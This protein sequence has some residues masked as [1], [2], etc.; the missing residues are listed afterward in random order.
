[1]AV[2]AAARSD[3][4]VDSR[5]ERR[6]AIGRMMQEQR[7]LDQFEFHDVQP[8]RRI[9]DHVDAGIDR[10]R[11]RGRQRL[12]RKDPRG[13]RTEEHTSELQSLMR[14]SYAVFCLKKQKRQN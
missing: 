10:P 8:A 13:I 1:M 2:A 9:A 4:A 7:R 3:G 5:S 14:L 11:W 6:A 12:R